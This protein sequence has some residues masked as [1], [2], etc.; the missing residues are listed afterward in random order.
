MSYTES[1]AHR[2]SV[3]AFYCHTMRLFHLD[4]IY[5]F[6]PLIWYLLILRSLFLQ[7]IICHHNLALSRTYIV[8]SE[9]A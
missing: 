9:I 7:E 1:N 5:H 8:L 2:L 4:I 6:I 3:I